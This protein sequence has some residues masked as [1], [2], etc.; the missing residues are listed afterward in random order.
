MNFPVEFSV[1]LN[2]FVEIFL[3]IIK[4]VLFLWIILLKL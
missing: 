4:K 2:E 3:L 1:F